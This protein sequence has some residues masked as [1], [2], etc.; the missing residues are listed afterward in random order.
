[1]GYNFINL[2]ADV[3]GLGSYW[4]NLIEEAKKQLA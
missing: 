1:M 4:K 3:L 2:G